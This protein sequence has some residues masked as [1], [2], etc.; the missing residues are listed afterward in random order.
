MS[1]HFLAVDLGASSGRVVLGRW[2]GERFELE[3]L[4]CFPNESVRVLGHA[5]WD[6]LAIWEQI[7]LGLRR[8]RQ[9]HGRDPSGIGVDTWGVDY[10]LL[11]SAGRLLGPPCHYRDARTEGMEGRALRHRS[12]SAHLRPHRHSV[13][14][15]QHSRSAHRHGGR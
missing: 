6:V 1:A 10:A 12:Q 7:Q 11:D 2:D 9:E 5:Y 15:H 13:H 4:H 8:Y 14:A 3:A